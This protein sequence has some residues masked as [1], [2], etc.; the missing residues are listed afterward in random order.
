VL[1]WL[2]FALSLACLLALLWVAIMFVD[3]LLRLSG[4]RTRNARQDTR[5]PPGTT[6][7][8]VRLGTEPATRA[9]S[10]SLRAPGEP[11]ADTWSR[12]VDTLTP[13]LRLLPSKPP[14]LSTVSATT[15]DGDASGTP[16]Y[17][18]TAD[19]FFSRPDSLP[20]LGPHAVCEIGDEAPALVV[21]VAKHTECDRDLS[22]Y[23]RA[24]LDYESAS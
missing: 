7:R 15:D 1:Y 3:R 11:G 17:G 21:S 8:P 24:I 14:S 10:R 19:R 4:S 9:A 6:A 23:Q 16:T 20:A 2:R 18:V 5:R 13:T 22:P 12:H